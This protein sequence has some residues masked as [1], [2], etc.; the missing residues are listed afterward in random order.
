MEEN[1]DDN[2]PAKFTKV[3]FEKFRRVVDYMRTTEYDQD[4]VTQG[5]RDFYNW[6][7]ELDFRRGTNFSSTF[8]EMETFFK[9]CSKL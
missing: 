9:E 5:Q 2:D 6:F 1:I 7:T 8:P 3:E 4:R